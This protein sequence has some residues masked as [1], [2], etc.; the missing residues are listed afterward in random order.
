MLIMKRIPSHILSAVL[1][2][3]YEIHSTSH[4][5]QSVVSI[6]NRLGFSEVTFKTV[7]N[8]LSAVVHLQAQDESPLYLNA[9]VDRPFQLASRDVVEELMDFVE[10][11]IGG[12]IY[13]YHKS[14]LDFLWDPRRSGPFHVFSLAARNAQ[15]KQHLEVCLKYRESYCIQGLELVLAPGVPDSAPSL[16]DP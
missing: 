3:L 7:Y 11:K 15:D 5:R 12:S 6:S 9:D 4:N 13:F 10:C 14:F 2:F 16:S 8:H 1:L